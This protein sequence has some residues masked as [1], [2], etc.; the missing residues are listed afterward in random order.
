MEQVVLDQHFLDGYDDWRTQGLRI[1]VVYRY[2][3]SALKELARRKTLTIN[4]PCVA[5]PSPNVYVVS[6]CPEES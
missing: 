5:Q 4:G 1:A 6:T 3:P 2:S